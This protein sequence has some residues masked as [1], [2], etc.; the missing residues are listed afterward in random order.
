MS[1]L[2]SSYLIA[3]TLSPLCSPTDEEYELL[4][5]I[6]INDSEELANLFKEKIVPHVQEY[7]EQSQ[8]I[9]KNTLSFYIKSENL[10]LG[11][12][13]DAFHIPFEEPENTSSFLKTLWGVLFGDEPI[14]DKPLTEYIVDN[15]EAFVNSL[16]RRGYR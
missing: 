10:E 5:E 12:V 14:K 9:I 4:S 3:K 1:I 8:E 16:Y 2:V 11:R 7:D 13:F 6:D 15:S